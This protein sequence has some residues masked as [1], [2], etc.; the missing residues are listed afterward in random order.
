VYKRQLGGKVAGVYVSR[1]SGEAGA[2]TFIEI[3][4]AAS[5]TRNNQPLFVVDGVPIDNS[6]NSNNSIGGV[7]ESNRA[8][9]LNPDDIESLSVLKGGAAT[10]LYGL[11]A[12]N[13][14]IIITTKQGQRTGAGKMNVNLNSSIRIEKVTQLPLLQKSFAQGSDLYMGSFGRS[15]LQYPDDQLYNA[16][17]WGPKL[18]DLGYTTDPNYIP[19]NEWYESG[20]IP[21][22]EWIANWDPNGRL[23]VANH[24]LADPN[25]PAIAYDHFDFFQQAVSYKN[26]FDISGG[27]ETSTFYLSVSNSKDEGVVPNNT[28]SKTTIKFS[29]TREVAVSYTHLRAHET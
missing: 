23:V 7:S 1:A 4:G 18:R 19:A 6:G 2:S 21:M 17:S 25:A 3:R 20:W 26:H 14:A 12:A 8:I 10:A 11:R 29:G 22:D 15:S 16:V 28:F 13:G 24:P 27:D 5:L 9:D